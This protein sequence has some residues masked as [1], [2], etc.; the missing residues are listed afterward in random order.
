LSLDEE[1]L[2][3][4]GY[5]QEFKCVFSTFEVFGIFFSIIWLFPVI[6]SAL[7]Y[8]MLNGG[9]SAMVWGWFIG[10]LFRLSIGIRMAELATAN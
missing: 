10:S 5:K 7:I 6:A 3:K 9:P 1:I 8:A 4:P 2:A